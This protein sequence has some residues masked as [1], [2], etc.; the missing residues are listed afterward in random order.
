MSKQTSKLLVLLAMLL[1]AACQTR[2]EPISLASRNLLLWHSWNETEAAALTTVLQKFNEINPDVQVISQQVPP[3]NLR[4]QYEQT[5][6]LGLGPDLFIGPGEW[7]VPLADQGLILD[8]TPFE[9]QTDFYLTSAVGTMTYDDGLYGLPLAL[10]PIAL[11]Y[12]TTLV[13]TPAADLDQWLAQAANGRSVAMD[14]NFLPAYWG[15]QAFGG[16]L[17]DESGRVVLD[18]GGFANWLRWLKNAQ[19]APGM[20]LSRDQASLRDLFFSGRTAYYTGSPDDLLAAQAA[21]G[22]DNLSVVPLPAGP[23]GPSGPLL[24]VEAIYFNPAARLQQTERA[25]EL[26][27]YLTNA[28]QSTTLL[29]EISR[30]PANR[31]VS[32]DPRLH[33]AEAGFAAQART[34]V[35]VPNL[36]Q[37]EM[38]FTQVDDLYRAALAGVVDIVEATNTLTAELNSTLGFSP[39]EDVV[40]FCQDEGILRI[41]HPWNGRLAAILNQFVSDYQAN[42]PDVR[43]LVTEI[44]EEQ[45]F[46]LYTTTGAAGSG[47]LLPDLVLGPSVWV[48]P[49]LEAKTIQPITQFISP[50]VRQR[51][52]PAAISTIE[53][54]SELYGLPLLL[55]LNVLYYDSEIIS[56]PPVTLAEFVQRAGSDGAALPVGFIE[57]YWGAAAYGGQLFTDENR[58]ALVET[59]FVEWLTW[60]AAAQQDPDILL[61]E[62]QEL[63]QEAF[64]TGEVA[65]LVGHSSALGLLEQHMAQGNL[66]VASLPAGP[67]GEAHPWLQTAA[68]FLTAGRT[69]EQRATALAFTDFVTN[70][71]N[72]TYLMESARLT[73]VN[74]NVVVES[75]STIGD[76]LQSVRNAFVPLN[77]PELTA[78]LAE[79]DQ[80]YQDVLSGAETP[81][82]AACAFTGRVDR[83]NGFTVT[84]DD[85]PLRCRE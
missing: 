20:I 56:N 46:E 7:L 66:Q 3:E 72:Q 19:S 67:G 54:Q 5:A 75:S 11:F 26:A 47:N 79:G 6:S 14:I 15:I 43:I 62:N 82:A 2:S 51:F 76:F 44:S 29:R 64:T 38:V 42:C 84:P 32:V 83:A 45:L 58:L 70:A 77:V 81:L 48:L 60:L 21:L 50:E 34:A 36:S 68:F 31:N 63:L 65:M 35:P 41:W 85:L 71:A 52:I 78:V 12:N 49:F 40:E 57:A 4:R 24:N 9:P 80:V 10:R 22:A 1:L 17:F 8:I 13:D 27:A 25:L 73:P 28:S 55:D 39:S 69:D 74:V 16:R 59:G 33:P 18:E 61:A 30:I 37:R 53:F 23:V